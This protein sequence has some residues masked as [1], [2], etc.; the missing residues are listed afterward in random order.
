MLGDENGC[1]LVCRLIV[2]QDRHLWDTEKISVCI[3]LMGALAS[4][5]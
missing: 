2:E 1:G 5:E 4:Q 3:E